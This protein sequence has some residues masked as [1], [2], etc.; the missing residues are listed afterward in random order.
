MIANKSGVR[1]GTTPTSI[2]IPFN[3]PSNPIAIIQHAHGGVPVT[4]SVNVWTKQKQ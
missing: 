1:V 2:T 4:Y 3:C